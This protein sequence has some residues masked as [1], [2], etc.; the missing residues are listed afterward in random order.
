MKHK[1][2]LP[3]VIRLVAVRGGNISTLHLPDEE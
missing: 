1:I 2:L 3:I